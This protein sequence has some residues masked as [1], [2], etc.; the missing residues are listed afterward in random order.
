MMTYFKLFPRFPTRHADVIFSL[1]FDDHLK[2]LDLVFSAIATA[3]ITLSPPKCHLGYQSLL[4]LGQKLDEPRNAHELQHFLAFEIAKQVLTN[5]PVRG[6]AIPADSAEGDPLKNIFVRAEPESGHEDTASQE[7]KGHFPE[8]YR[9][10]S[11]DLGIDRPVKSLNRS[12]PASTTIQGTP[13][14]SSDIRRLVEFE[15]SGIAPTILAYL[16][17]WRLS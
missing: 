12:R 1:T 2:H 5:A 3:N 17:H 16:Y 9:K 15:K 10:S 8:S 4:L 13:E 7:E 14:C 6:Y 11:D